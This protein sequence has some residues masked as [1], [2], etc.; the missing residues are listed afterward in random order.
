MCGRLTPG[1]R[2]LR[3]GARRAG[4]ALQRRTKPGD[5]PIADRDR[6]GCVDKR[7][8]ST[9]RP[10]VVATRGSTTRSALEA[11]HERYRIVARFAGNGTTYVYASRVVNGTET[12]IGSAVVVPAV[13]FQTGFTF[14]GQ[15]TGTNPTTIR[16]KAWIGSEPAT[17]STRRPTASARR[18]PAKAGSAPTRRGHDQRSAGLSRGRLRGQRHGRPTAAARGVTFVGAGDIAPSGNGDDAT[19]TLLDGIPGTVF[20]LGDNVYPNGRR[21]LQQLRRPTWGRHKS[22]TLPVA[23]NHEYNTANAAGY[24]ATSARRRAIRQGLLLERPRH[25]ARHRAERELHDRLVRR[26]IGAG[27]VA[28]RGPRGEHRALHRRDVGT[29]R[30][31]RPGRHGNSTRR[32]RSGTRS[33]STTPTSC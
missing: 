23:G 28:A 17:G 13:D 3:N 12:Q 33:T 32:P 20:T 21:R 9:R 5:L 14:R 1:R 25:L 15:A 30:A 4:C 27:A 10:S 26:R 29:S 24:Y 11:R 22:R 7:R 8:V 31:S 16:V 6:L 18:S 2:L 19:A